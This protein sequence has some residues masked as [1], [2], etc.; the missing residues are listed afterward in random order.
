MK[1]ILHLMGDKRTIHLS[2]KGKL[3][4]VEWLL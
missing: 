4:F 3:I 2:K 1:I